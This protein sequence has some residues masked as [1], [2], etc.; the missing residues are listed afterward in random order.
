MYS[1]R[2]V[3][4]WLETTNHKDI[5]TMYLMFAFWCGLAGSGLSSLIRLELFMP[6]FFL[7]S[8]QL[9]NA[10]ITSHAIMMIFFMVMPGLIG[11]FGNWMVPLMLGSPDMSFPRLNSFS[12]WL[13][14]AALV[15]ILSS[16]L[17]GS[18][19]GTS[20]TVYPPL[21]T[22]GH[23]D[24]SVDLAILSLHCAG[25]SSLLGGI[26][27]MSTIFN[28][29]VTSL[30]MESMALFCWTV[31]VTVFL[32][33][34]TLPVLAGAI[35]M[36]LLD[37]NFNT[38][39]FDVES[40]GNPLLYQHLFWF[41][42]HPEVYVLILPAF[43]IMSH[44]SLYITGKKEVFGSAGMVYAIV[45]IGVVGCV[46]WGHHMYTAGLDLDS[47]AYFTASTMIIAVP[48][49]VK[50]FSWAATL[51]GSKMVFQPLVMWIMGFL[52]LFTIGG[53][54]GL[55]LSNSCLDV[56][57]HDTYYV[58]AHFHYVLSMGAVFGLF[59]GLSLWWGTMSGYLYN[60]GMMYAVFIVIF[61]ST[62]LTFFPLHFAGMQG[63]PR[64]YVDY[65]DVF[66]I[67][68]TMSSV[69][70]LI[71][72]FGLFLFIFVILESFVSSRYVV[73]SYFVNGIENM[74]GG[75]VFSHSNGLWPCVY[76]GH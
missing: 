66:S 64:K 37:R 14:C 26:N 47:R 29:R 23:P 53:L 5:G 60:K 75:Y 52:S 72:I 46:V 71:S 34:L 17:S 9:Y 15:L 2:S 74:Y 13:L 11:G 73:S 36:L 58:V 21:S 44:S 27:F 1:N 39:F 57:F 7:G 54:T 59:M 35:T 10:V 8:G 30:N 32:L 19:C 24:H 3:L 51:Y 12:F 61:F 22:S 41:F 43:G 38:S 55:V 31:L 20:W 76:F 56:I 40:G 62:N 16:C 69:G 18:S 42:G 6:G 68:N 48:T 28:M 65:P 49:G 45:T 25:L 50:V 67:W 33:V 4:Y 63:M 70:S